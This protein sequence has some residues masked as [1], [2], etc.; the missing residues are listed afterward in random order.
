MDRLKSCV[1]TVIRE[2]F[3]KTFSRSRSFCLLKTS[4][5]RVKTNVNVMSAYLVYNKADE[6]LLIDGG[7]I[8]MYK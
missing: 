6:R 3:S 4:F 1:F 7:M 8:C 5:L 2:K